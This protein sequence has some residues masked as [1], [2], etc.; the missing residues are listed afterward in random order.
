VSFSNEDFIRLERLKRTVDL[1]DFPPSNL[2]GTVD[3]V[4]EVPRQS[5]RLSNPSKE[6]LDV[7]SSHFNKAKIKLATFSI[8]TQAPPLHVPGFPSKDRFA[9]GEGGRKDKEHSTGSSLGESKKHKQRC[10]KARKDKPRMVEGADITRD[11]IPELL[12]KTV[13]GRF[14]GKVVSSSS[15]LSWIDSNWRDVLGYNLDFHTLARGWLSFKFK[16][17][18]DMLKIFNREWGWGP[19]IL[20]LKEWDI[21]FDPTRDALA[22]TKIWVILQNL[23]LVFWEDAIMESIGNMIGRFICCEPNW[24]GKT[25]L[26]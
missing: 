8:S 17:D 20:V 10:W 15:L 13:V 25:N 24:K 3:G 6:M 1:D 11:E 23:S 18:V 7:D 21:S 12:G 4:A 19:S 14:S 2:R 5:R 9:S 22:P 26:R 16:S